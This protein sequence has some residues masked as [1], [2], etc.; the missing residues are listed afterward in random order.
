MNTKTH[1]LGKPCKRGHINELGKT[2]RRNDNGSCMACVAIM[3]NKR[4]TAQKALHG[5]TYQGTPCIQGHLCDDGLT[6]RHSHNGICVLCH[7]QH[8]KAYRATTNGK[9]KYRQYSWKYDGMPTPTRPA[10]DVCELCSKTNSSGKALSLDHCHVSGAF[11]GWLCTP[12]NAALGNLGDSLE[13]I[14]RAADY[15]RKNTPAT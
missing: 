11:R 2:V 13:G 8:K 15:L 4:F 12:C 5:A 3:R 7:R 14:L 1:Y 10:P 9:Q 6:T